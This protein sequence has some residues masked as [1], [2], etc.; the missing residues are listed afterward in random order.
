MKIGEKKQGN[1][2]WLILSTAI[3]H[4]IFKIFNLELLRK[5]SK[6]WIMIF[7]SFLLVFLYIFL[8]SLPKAPGCSISMRWYPEF[9]PAGLP[10]S[11]F[12][13]RPEQFSCRHP[14]MSRKRSIRT[15]GHRS[16]RIERVSGRIR[17]KVRP[18]R[19]HTMSIDLW[20]V[21][22]NWLKTLW[23]SCSLRWGTRNRC[24]RRLGLKWASTV[25]RIWSAISPNSCRRWAL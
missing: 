19:R 2:N 22:P 4:K 7:T 12:S 8:Q 15:S 16:G 18:G 14:L 10:V 1:N 13:S 17:R 25:C 23:W 11:S 3:I 5:Y 24:R 20:V 9:L 6:V 21:F